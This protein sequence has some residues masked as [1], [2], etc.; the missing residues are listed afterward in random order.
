MTKEEEAAE[1]IITHMKPFVASSTAKRNNKLI[2]SLGTPIELTTTPPPSIECNLCFKIYDFDDFNNHLKN[3]HYVKFTNED[4][5]D[6]QGMKAD[7]VAI[8]KEF[9]TTGVKKE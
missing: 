2:H 3:K 8:Y 5:I 6:W 1:K 4:D 7:P 9:G